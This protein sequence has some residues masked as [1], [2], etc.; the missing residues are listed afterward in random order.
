LQEV[1]PGAF[2]IQDVAVD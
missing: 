2:R 1:T